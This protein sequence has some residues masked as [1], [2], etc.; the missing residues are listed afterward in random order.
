[1]RK[2]QKIA[3]IFMELFEFYDYVIIYLIL[4]ILLLCCFFA[5]FVVG[6]KSIKILP[7]RKS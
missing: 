6:N 3:D 4:F 5:I 2:G 7:F 1:M